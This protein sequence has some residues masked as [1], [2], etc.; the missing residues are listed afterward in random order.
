MIIRPCEALQGRIRETH[1][2]GL[3]GKSFFDR[4][5]DIDASIDVAADDVNLGYGFVTI[6]VMQT[7]EAN[8]NR[9]V[10]LRID[11][12]LTSR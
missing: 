7:H 2:T 12:I 3:E 4:L 5:A 6:R 10:R 11:R 9:D 8:L 1:V